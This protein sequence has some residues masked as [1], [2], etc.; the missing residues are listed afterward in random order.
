MEV[1][2]SEVAEHIKA[3]AETETLKISGTVRENRSTE[4]VDGIDVTFY[5]KETNSYVGSASKSTAVN[6][7][8]TDP[9]RLMEAVLAFND[10][11]AGVE[12]QL[13]K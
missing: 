4:G 12:S 11:I 7:N 10:F 13:A 6:I 9:T 1:T 5:D 3:N 8:I 2:F